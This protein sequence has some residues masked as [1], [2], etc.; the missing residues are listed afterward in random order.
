MRDLL[1]TDDS[2]AGLILRV[3]LGV[4]MLPHGAQKL[5]GW[6]G[7]PGFS[8]TMAM[9]TDKMHIPM[10]LALLVIIAESFGSLALIAGLYVMALRQNLPEPDARSLAFVALVAANLGLCK[11]AFTASQRQRWAQNPSLSAAGGRVR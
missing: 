8:G 4:V 2:W 10:F 3:T 9:F 1:K 7:G 5:L 11:T 6:F